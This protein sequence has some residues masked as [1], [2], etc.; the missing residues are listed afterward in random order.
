V[1]SNASGFPGPS[2]TPF[3]FGL[4]ESA[5]LATLFQAASSTVVPLFRSFQQIPSNLTGVG[6]LVDW[7]SGNDTV[8]LD[9]VKL[10]SPVTIPGPI[11]GAGLPG[12]ILAS[13]GLLGWWRGR[14]KF[15]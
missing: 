13:G 4:T 2:F 8:N 15:A 9:N 14:Q 11:V 3:N 7:L 1:I 10:E 12:L 6:I 5:G